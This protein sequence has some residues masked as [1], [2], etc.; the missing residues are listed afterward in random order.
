MGRANNLRQ[1]RLQR[2]AQTCEEGT[3][4]AEPSRRH[5][6]I[7][8]ELQEWQQ[9][10]QQAREQAEWDMQAENRL[11]VLVQLMEIA[12][13][14]GLRKLA[15]RVKEEALTPLD[16][17]RMPALPPV[18]CVE[19]VWERLSDDSAHHQGLRRRLQRLVVQ[20]SLPSPRIAVQ[21]DQLE[22]EPP[23]SHLPQLASIFR[24]SATAGL[25]PPPARPRNRTFY[26]AKA[27][28][29]SLPVGTLRE[30]C[31]A[32]DHD[33]KNASKA[34]LVQQLLNSRTSRSDVIGHLRAQRQPR[35]KVC[36]FAPKS[37]FFFSV[38]VCV[39][40]SCD[41]FL[42]CLRQAGR[43]SPQ[44][45]RA[46]FSD[47]RGPC[48]GKERC[49]QGR[50]VSSERALDKQ[51]TQNWETLRKMGNVLL[52]NTFPFLRFRRKQ[53][54]FVKAFQGI[55]VLNTALEETSSPICFSP[56]PVPP[57]FFFLFLL[58]ADNFC[59]F[60]EAQMNKKNSET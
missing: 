46:H 39:L 6:E 4:H 35:Q 36:C 10:Q 24:A 18:T 25:A 47:S 57:F 29:S 21:P 32:K 45:R 3:V 9:R 8:K 15:A 5:L 30:L 33:T 43:T 50:R 26:R 12:K 59:V 38:L 1:L 53:V 27:E 37:L 49:L 40:L 7:K 51:R 41:A 48:Q 28:I 22:P 52:I 60:R 31:A 11:A 17:T 13:D 42:P 23:E 34:D 58:L 55:F 2:T 19:D 20:H 44:T 54:E 14:A 56:A 16:R